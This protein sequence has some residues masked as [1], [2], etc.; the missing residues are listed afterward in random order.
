MPGTE[1]GPSLM[2]MKTPKEAG[3]GWKVGLLFRGSWR[4]G[5]KGRRGSLNTEARRLRGSKKGSALN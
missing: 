4:W 1:P 5:W 3:I 2:K